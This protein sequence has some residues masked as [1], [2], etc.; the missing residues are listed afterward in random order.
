MNVTS[1]KSTR[2]QTGT[3]SA[4]HLP[5]NDVYFIPSLVYIDEPQPSYAWL[6]LAAVAQPKSTEMPDYPHNYLA[7]PMFVHRI[8][9][10]LAIH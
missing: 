2:R 5:Q 6:W 4:L 10:P 8:A 3:A 1:W 9:L 7:I